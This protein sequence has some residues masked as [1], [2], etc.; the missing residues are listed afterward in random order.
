MITIEEVHEAQKRIAPY[1]N[2]T[3]LL[4][5]NNL[6]EYLG[7]QVYA[8]MES[9]QKTNSF[10]VRGALN[11]LLNLSESELKEGVI[12]ASSG[13]HGKA[14]AY[15]AKQLGSKAHVVVPENAPIIKVK[16]IQS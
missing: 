6:D 10:K 14:I 16:G 8:K 3:P 11:A 7:C 1:I 12:T 4:H 2:E 5:L 13:N 15:A 9:F